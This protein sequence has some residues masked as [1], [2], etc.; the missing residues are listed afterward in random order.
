[1]APPSANAELVSF[2]LIRGVVEAVLVLVSVVVVDELLFLTRRTI[3]PT[4]MTMT[5][6]T[7]NDF[8]VF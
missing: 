2:I 5:R 4:T 7:R 1:M 3:P 8:I 6:I